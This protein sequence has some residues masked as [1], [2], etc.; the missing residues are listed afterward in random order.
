MGNTPAPV[1]SHGQR[2]TALENAN[3][4]RSR[5]SRMKRDIKAG[6]ASAVPLLLDPPEWLETAKVFD[7][8]LAVPKLGRVKV[9]RV[10]NRVRVSPSKTVAGISDRQRLELAAALGATPAQLAAYIPRDVRLPLARSRYLA[11]PHLRRESDDTR[12]TD[13]QCA[14]LALAAELGTAGVAHMDEIAERLETSTTGVGLARGALQRRGCLDEFGA[15]TL[16][17]RT[18]LRD[19]SRAAAARRAA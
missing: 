19:S 12:P 16:A 3:R 13:F 6:R 5:R 15:P 18:L 2:M 17:G 14:V 9:N 8:L 4:I 7:L 10:L 1:R 11:E